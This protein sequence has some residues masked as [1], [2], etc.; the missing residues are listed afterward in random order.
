MSLHTTLP[1]PPTETQYQQYLSCYWPKLDETLTVGSWEDLEQI[2]TVRLTFVKATFVLATFVTIRNISAVN[3]FWPNIKG[4]F[5]GP[6][7]IDANCHG[8]KPNSKTYQAEHFRPKSCSPCRQCETVWSNPNLI[9]ADYLIIEL[10]HQMIVRHMK[11]SAPPN[12]WLNKRWGVAQCSG[13]AS[14]NF[15]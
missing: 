5:L 3:Q 6:S 2:P 8:A 14:C 11:Y 13:H 10:Y 12:I 15:L 4:R 7:L 1:T 9:M